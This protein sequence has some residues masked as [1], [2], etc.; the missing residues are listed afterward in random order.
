MQGKV[1]FV[2]F[3]V[4]IFLC[5]IGAI[6][7]MVACGGGGGGGGIIGGGDGGGGGGGG[8]GQSSSINFQIN[9]TQGAWIIISIKQNSIQTSQYSFDF[10]NPNPNILANISDPD[11]NESQFYGCGFRPTRKSGNQNIL[12]S[13]TPPNFD[14]ERNFTVNKNMPNEAQ[15]IA[16]CRYI[17]SNPDFA[18]WVDL[19]DF[20]LGYVNQTMINSLGARF[21]NDYQTLVNRLGYTPPFYVDILITRKVDDQPNPRI[22]GYFYAAEDIERI[23]VHPATFYMVYQGQNGQYN[24]A[25]VTTVHE[26][27]HLLSYHAS[28]VGNKE[29]WI[30]EGLSTYGEEICGY[31]SGVRN[32]SIIQFLSSPH[33]TPLVVDHQTIEVRNYGK[34]YLFVKNLEQRFNNAWRNM[35]RSS[36]D[37]INMIENINGNEDFMTTVEVF[38]TAVILDIQNHPHFGFDGIDLNSI[39]RNQDGIG[40]DKGVFKF[41]EVDNNGFK[42]RTLR[43]MQNFD[44]IERYTS[45]YIYRTSAPFSGM[46]T[47]DVFANI[48]LTNLNTNFSPF[49]TLAN[50][51]FT[52][53]DSPPAVI[54]VVYR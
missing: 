33:Q 46:V 16:K 40:N 12:Y 53:I 50:Y 11:N 27:V 7:I 28:S 36:V 8:G 22:I 6:F 37:G 51:T 30:E 34:S 49:N 14:E 44:I 1:K 25:H 18:I 21:I 24:E 38:N 41:D 29:V 35:M 20:N 54:T 3:Y 15:V 2:S 47:L 26:F 43:Q 39:D 19:Q 32:R 31:L 23:N 13:Q 48:S 45:F 4:W 10:S 52:R 17:S 42:D 5:I 9:S